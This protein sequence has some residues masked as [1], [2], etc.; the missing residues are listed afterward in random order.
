MK[1]LLTL[2]ALFALAPA[3]FA[4]GVND[5][6]FTTSEWMADINYY[7]S[8]F[9]M[10]DSADGKGFTF[11]VDDK[12][13]NIPLSF[14]PQGVSNWLFNPNETIIVTVDENFYDAVFPNENDDPNIWLLGASG[15]NN[16][17]AAIF[18][19]AYNGP[20]EYVLT[21]VDNTGLEEGNELDQMFFEFT[22][23]STFFSMIPSINADVF[24]RAQVDSV[25]LTV[26]FPEKKET[27]VPEPMAA[28]YG[29]FGLG[30]LLGIKRRK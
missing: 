10:S 29:L 12:S 11:F 25:T 27:V 23:G 5:P 13:L 15:Y 16:G 8:G 20:G 17:E 6:E 3:A 4:A 1:K 30:S 19:A 14:G 9:A 7:G 28:V 26:R 22:N 24:D 18:T 2:L 21:L